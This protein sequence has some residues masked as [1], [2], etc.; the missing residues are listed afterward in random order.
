[1]ARIGIVFLVGR[2]DKFGS[3]FDSV[4][5]I[6]YSRLESVRKTHYG[7]I[8]FPYLRKLMGMKGQKQYTNIILARLKG[9]I[10]I[11]EANSLW[12]TYHANQDA[13]WQIHA[14]CQC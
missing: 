12:E 7:L 3:R 13:C 14:S 4:Y 8:M 9:I 10:T 2:M 1:L 5:I 6:C 11:E